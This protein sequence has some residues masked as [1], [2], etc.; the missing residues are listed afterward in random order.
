MSE[1]IIKENFVK[2]FRRFLD[3]H[4]PL[5]SILAGVIGCLAVPGGFI[6]E[7]DIFI[8]I[9]LSILVGWLLYLMVRLIS[10]R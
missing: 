4:I 7:N 2:P 1:N 5:C 10:I 3:A 9:S 6:F 8:G